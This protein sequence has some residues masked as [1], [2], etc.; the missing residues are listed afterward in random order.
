MWKGGEGGITDLENVQGLLAHTHPSD[1]LSPGRRSCIVCGQEIERE[2]DYIGFG[3][4]TADEGSP[5]YRYNYTDAHISHL[6]NWV[7]LARVVRLLEEFAESGAWG[8]S[9]IDVLVAELRSA[10]P[11]TAGPQQGPERTRL[12]IA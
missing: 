9:A 10:A 5:L 1:V 4:L 11:E 6:P 12:A 3:H 2:V 8:G 7:E